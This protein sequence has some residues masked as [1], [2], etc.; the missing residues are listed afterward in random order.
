[1]GCDATPPFPD[2][3]KP[4]DFVQGLDHFGDVYFEVKSAYGPRP[5]SP[6]LWSIF[7]HRYD[8]SGKDI[9]FSIG[10]SAGVRRVVPAEMGLPTLVAKRSRIHAAVGLF[11]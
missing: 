2:G 9:G 3:I 6:H 1:M 10:P 4:G 11:A 8:K 5:D 7:C